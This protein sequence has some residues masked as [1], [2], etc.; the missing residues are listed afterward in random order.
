MR[1]VH[2]RLASVAQKRC[3]LKLP[4]DWP[5]TPSAPQNY[6]ARIRMAC[7]VYM[8][9]LLFMYDAA[10]SEALFVFKMAELSAYRDQHFRVM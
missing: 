5:I 3:M 8:T 9:S 7:G 10:I 6:P 1:K 2:F 4:F